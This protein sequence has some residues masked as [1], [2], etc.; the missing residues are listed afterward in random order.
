MSEHYSESKMA[1]EQLHGS[2]VSENSSRM[3]SNDGTSVA[4]SMNALNNSV[5]NVGADQTT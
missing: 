2:S 5:S 1:R 4:A 3:I